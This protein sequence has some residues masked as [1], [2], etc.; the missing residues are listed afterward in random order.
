MIKRFVCF[1]SH[2]RLQNKYE[3]CVAVRACTAAGRL[4][5][6][7]VMFIQSLG[8]RVRQQLGEHGHDHAAARTAGRA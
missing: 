4:R 6:I 2:L 5:A 8:E 1:A 3:S 7:D